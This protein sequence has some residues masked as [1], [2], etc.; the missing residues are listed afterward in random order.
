MAEYRIYA[1]L[2][3]SFGGAKFIDTLEFENEDEAA[4]YAFDTACEEFERCAGLYGL[5]SYKQIKEENPDLDDDD[6]DEI[7]NQERERWLS[8]KVE[9]V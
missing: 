8:Y 2:G 7:Y 3:G 5:A 6:L 4:D 1:G 9:R